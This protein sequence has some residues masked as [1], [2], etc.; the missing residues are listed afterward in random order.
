MSLTSTTIKILDHWDID[1]ETY[2]IEKL[3]Q[4][5]TVSIHGKES[6]GEISLEEFSGPSSRQ[7]EQAAEETMKRIRKELR[8]TEQPSFK[9]EE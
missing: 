2:Q 8:G 7:R 5:M 1:L 3:F 4:G 9:E 6:T